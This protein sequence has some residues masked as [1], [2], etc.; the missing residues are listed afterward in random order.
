MNDLILLTNFEKTADII[1]LNYKKEKAYSKNK[2]QVIRIKYFFSGHN[3]NVKTLFLH[4][5]LSTIRL[6]RRRDFEFLRKN[7]SI[8]INA[9][10]KKLYK[11]LIDIEKNKPS[12]L[13]KHFT[14]IKHCCNSEE[15]LYIRITEQLWSYIQQYYEFKN[16]YISELFSETDLNK[17]RKE[18]EVD[19]LLKKTLSSLEIKVDNLGG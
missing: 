1:A 17:K 3:F 4:P 2:N 5:P 11:I 13:R 6:K 15:Q 14:I 12:F 18:E 10:Y 16:E 9:F 8:S 7:R 19:D